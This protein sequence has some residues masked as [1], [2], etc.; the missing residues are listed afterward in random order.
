[1]SRKNKKIAKRITVLCIV[2]LLAVLLVRYI[3]GERQRAAVIENS[4]FTVYMLDVGQGDCIFIDNGDKDIIIDAGPGDVSNTIAA[5]LSS[6]GA[7]E[8]EYMFISHCDADHIGG[9]DDIIKAFDVKNVVMSEDKRTTKTYKQ[10]V[11]AMENKNITPV[12]AIKDDVF[13]VGEAHIEIL[14]PD[15]EKYEDVNEKSLVMLIN[16]DGAKY[17]FTGDADNL[18]ESKLLDGYSAEKLDCD[19]LKVGHHG[20]RTSS[21]EAFLDVV[22]PKFSLISVGQDN[23]YGHPHARTLNLLT[24][25]SEKIFRTDIDGMITICEKDGELYRAG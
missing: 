24:K 20:S 22:S 18:I 6:V 11:S 15:T 19:L 7:D 23:S 25:F 10:F 21:S 1:M 2:L 5:Q 14:S 4:D 16:F 13:D 17:L 12:F 3:I 9:A 8:I